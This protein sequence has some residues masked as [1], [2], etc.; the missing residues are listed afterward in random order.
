MKKFNSSIFAHSAIGELFPRSSKLSKL[1]MLF[2]LIS[3]GFFSTLSAQCPMGCSNMNLS[4]DTITGG[5]VQITPVMIMVDTSGCPA[6]TLSVELTDQY[7]RPIAGDEVNCDHVGQQLTAKVVEATTGNSCWAY[8]N[9][10]DKAGPRLDCIVDTIFCVELEKYELGTDRFPSGMAMDNCGGVE[11]FPVVIQMTCDEYTCEENAEFSGL[12]IR[13][14]FSKDRWGN[15]YECTDTFY[16]ARVPLDSIVCPRDTMFDCSAADT[17]DQDNDGYIDPAFTG[18]PQVFIENYK[19]GRDT[20]VDLYPSGDICKTYTHFKEHEWAIC[21]NGKKIRRTWE[22]VDWCRDTTIVCVQWIKIVDTTKPEIE[23]YADI[24]AIVAPHECKA[25]VLIPYPK[26]IYECSGIEKVKVQITYYDHHEN[27]SVTEYKDVLPGVGAYIYPKAGCWDAYVF[28]NDSCGNYCIDTLKVCVKDATPPTPV[29]DEITRTT[30]DPNECWARIYATTFDDGSH[31]NCCDKLHFSAAHMS[32]VEMYREFWHNEFK[33]ALG[34]TDYYKYHKDLEAWIEIWLDCNI[35]NDYVEFTGCSEDNMVVTRVYSKCHLYKYYDPHLHGD[36]EHDFYCVETYKKSLPGGSFAQD[37]KS[38]AEVLTQNYSLSNF[39][40]DI[41][42][43]A[44]SCIYYFSECMVEVNVDDKVDPYCRP[45]DDVTVYCDAVIQNP[46]AESAHYAECGNNHGGYGTAPGPIVIGPGSGFKNCIDCPYW[47]ELDDLDVRID[48]TSLFRTPEY[49]DNCKDVMIDSTTTGSLDDCGEGV[50]TRTWTIRDACG[51]STT[52]H[53]RVYVLHRSDF[54][55][56]FPADTTLF[57]ES[58]LA[59]D[60][61]PDNIGRP[62]VTDDECEQIGMSYSDETFTI[63]EDACLKIIRTWTIIDWC[64]YD[65]DVHHRSL[66]ICLDSCVASPTRYDINRSLK[67]NGDGYMKYTQIIKVRNQEAPELRVTEEVIACATDRETCVG[68]AR[69]V[70]E[71]SDDCTPDAELVWRIF[72]DEFSKGEYVELP[73]QFG[74]SATIDQPFPISKP[75]DPHKIKFSVADKC[76][77]LRD[78]TITFEIDLCKKP[79]P[80]C[81]NDLVVGLMGIDDDGDNAFDRG[82]VQIWAEDFDAG[83]FAYCLQDVVAFS[84]S[85]DTTDKYRDFT[86]DSIGVR[87]VEMWVTDSWGNQDFCVVDVTIQDNMGACSGLQLQTATISGEL[88]T[89]QN[90]KIEKVK[91][92][93]KGS[94]TQPVST[95][96]EGSFNFGNMVMGGTYSIIPDKDIN[97]V[98]GV[99]TLDLVLIQKHILGIAPL[100]SPYKIIAADIDDN[101]AVTALDLVQLRRL[102]LGIDESFVKNTS[103]RFVSKDYQFNDPRNPLTEDF[104]EAYSISNLA[105]DMKV[106]FVG[107]KVGDVNGTVSPSELQ[108]AQIRSARALVLQIDESRF[109]SQMELKV[110]V[111]A[112]N[113]A[114]ITGYQFTLEFD[115]SA[116]NLERVESGLL[117]VSDSNFGFHRLAEGKLST[118]WHNTS[119]VSA[120]NDEVL[121]TLVFNTLEFGNTKDMFKISSALTDAEAY[122]DQL[123]VQQVKLDIL[124]GNKIQTSDFVLLQ[125]SPN[126][127][128]QQTIIGFVLPEDSRAT[129]KIMDV[130][131]KL[132]KSY[133]GNYS[134]GL[135]QINITKSELNLA[136][137]LYYQLETDQFN[138]TKKMIIV[139]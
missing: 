65:P 39:L 119:P 37:K 11:E 92:E 10:E 48:P 96:V 17:L 16:V 75:G 106:D 91:V 103:W 42:G 85:A 136:G 53:Q 8:V 27:K 2:A 31:D 29:C 76:G 94:G 139:E 120:T 70:V 30:L 35:F 99:S 23:K 124:S 60:L 130:T 109:S 13:K 14:L 84:F 59:F 50:L 138:A 62:V 72:V 133:E 95:G 73:R 26:V 114:Q 79:T 61:D 24:D 40:N 74:G 36:S 101:G 66:D 122:D 6:P 7:G 121:F 71:A 46:A 12:C 69:F 135:N 19:P 51:N 32:E 44:D 54:E 127:F 132:I 15:S 88:V 18:V 34:N 33:S 113:F 58:N 112:A 5:T 1:W 90:I 57:C 100:N 118:S 49:G 82:M 64:E 110:P 117:D 126:P 128:N 134:K 78:T 115:A 67:D 111:T 4:L 81:H 137:V 63:V 56:K 47:L 9:V 55:V 68:N 93:L 28:V 87:T 131:G 89:E 105:E 3:V 80:Y 129:L 116:L 43:V 22:I 41:T 125:N 86:C 45:Y 98:N 21:G 38:L 123:E 108:G 77:N 20:L 104:M 102:I 107:L 83:S 52:C 97:P 25:H